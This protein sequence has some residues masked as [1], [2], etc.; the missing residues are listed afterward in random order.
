MKIYVV[1]DGCY[2]DYSVI[3]LRSKEEDARTLAEFLGED[4]RYFDMEVD[5]SGDLELAKIRETGA[6]TEEELTKAKEYIKGHFVL[7]LEDSRS[8]ADYYGHQELLQKELNNPE[9]TLRKIYAVTLKDIERVAKKYIVNE[10]LNLAIIG[11]FPEGAQKEFED[12]L[13]IK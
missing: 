13:K 1:T 11:N 2:S 5:G 10:T 4:G 8:V 6:V 3:C 12:L 7:D 9:E